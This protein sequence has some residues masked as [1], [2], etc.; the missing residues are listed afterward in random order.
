MEITTSLS[1]R[2]LNIHQIIFNH[3]ALGKYVQDLRYTQ[4]DAGRVGTE[5][6]SFEVADK[7]CYI[8]NQY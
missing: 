2:I 4:F 7:A 3:H 1:S 8:K 6:G 5:A